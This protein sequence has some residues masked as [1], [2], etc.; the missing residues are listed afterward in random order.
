MAGAVIPMRRGGPARGLNALSRGPFPFSLAR[1]PSFFGTMML[2]EN[3][4]EAFGLRLPKSRTGK[5]TRKGL[6]A[7][8]RQGTRAAFRGDPT[9]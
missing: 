4:F 3:R 8:V 7:L 6:A 9:Y 2:R 1:S 5:K